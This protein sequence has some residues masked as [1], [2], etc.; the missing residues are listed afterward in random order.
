MILYFDFDGTL[1]DVKDKYYD[2]YKAFVSEHE[3]VTLAKE[4]FW[5]LKKNLMRLP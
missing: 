2:I 4:E 5:N 3:G 1:V